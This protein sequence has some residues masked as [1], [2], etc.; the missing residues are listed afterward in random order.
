MPTLKVT[1][2]GLTSTPLYVVTDEALPLKT[3]QVVARYNAERDELYLTKHG[4]G[5]TRE[6]R[7]AVTCAGCCDCGKV[8]AGGC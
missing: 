4:K 5:R 6:I 7:A 2:H 3:G 8:L 1:R